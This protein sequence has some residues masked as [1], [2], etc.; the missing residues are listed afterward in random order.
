MPVAP[1]A[2]DPRRWRALWVVLLAACMDLLDATVVLLALPFIQR[3]LGSSDAQVQWTVAA[4]QLASAALLIT[5]G[6]LGDI[7]GGKRLYLVGV[8]GFTAAS[9]LCGRAASPALLIGARVL[10]G[11]LAG[12]MVPRVLSLIQASFPPRERGAALGAFGAVLGLGNVG[13]PLIAGLI[14][15]ADL[16]GLGWRPIFLLNLPLGLVALVGVWALQRDSRAPHPLR[17]D[18]P[19]VALAT[20]ALLLVLYPLVQGR[21]RARLSAGAAAVREAP[22]P[23]MGRRPLTRTTI[24]GGTTCTARSKPQAAPWRAPAACPAG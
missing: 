11:A 19:G 23:Q 9:A 7:F 20:T 4:Y 1:V 10:Q 5:G 18:L 21:E 12:L 8:A 6:R 22:G 13:G 16:L 24:R 14:L 15:Q 2:A 3:D 17:P